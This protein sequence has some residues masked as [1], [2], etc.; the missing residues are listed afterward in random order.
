MDSGWQTYPFGWSYFRVFKFVIES[1]FTCE[2]RAKLMRKGWAPWSDW[3]KSERV[4]VCRRL[5]D[6]GCIQK[7]R[8]WSECLLNLRNRLTR[9][10]GQRDRTDAERWAQVKDLNLNAVPLART[11]AHSWTLNLSV[12]TFERS[13]TSQFKWTLQARRV[14]AEV[15]LWSTNSETY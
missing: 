4:A 13:R 15:E 14:T 3:A 12:A 8:S 6:S 1:E 9:A 2:K 10:E 11:L 7:F 5:G